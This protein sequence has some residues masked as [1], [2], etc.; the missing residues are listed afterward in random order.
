MTNTTTTEKENRRA[1]TAVSDLLPGTYVTD[2][3]NGAYLYPSAD[4]QVGEAWIAYPLPLSDAAADQRRPWCFSD[5]G[6][7]VTRS[8]SLTVESPAAD[9]AAWIR[10]SL[11]AASVVL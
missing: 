1:T 8:S 9:V 2:D 3:G 4:G 6:H 11:A 5:A 7:H 10:Q